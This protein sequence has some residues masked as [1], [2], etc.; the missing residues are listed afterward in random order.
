MRDRKVGPQR[1]APWVNNKPRIPQNLAHQVLAPR[2]NLV[3]HKPGQRSFSELL[4][5]RGF[6]DRFLHAAL[7]FYIPCGNNGIFVKVTLELW[8]EQQHSLD[9]HGAYRSG[10][11]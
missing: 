7:G 4:L 8:K 3:F 6:L 1:G 5:T 10:E 2:L 9:G 11:P